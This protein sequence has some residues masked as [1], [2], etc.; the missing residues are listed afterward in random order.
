MAPLGRCYQNCVWEDLVPQQASVRLESAALTNVWQLL[1]RKGE[2]FLGSAYKD[3]ITSFDDFQKFSV[4]N[5][6]IYWKCV[7]NEMSI[8]FSKPPECILHDRPPGEGPLSHPSGKWLPRASINPA[9]NCLN[10]N[11]ERCLNDIVIIWHEEQHD[12]LPLK[13]M[14]LEELRENVWYAANSLLLLAL[15]LMFFYLL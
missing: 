10:V 4:S 7:L 14:I 6:E 2:E 1:E 13:R 8:S 3:P 9:H 11:S 15:T 12:D 5:P